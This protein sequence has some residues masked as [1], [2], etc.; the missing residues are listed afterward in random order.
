MKNRNLLRDNLVDH[1]WVDCEGKETAR[2]KPDFYEK[3][4]APTDPRTGNVLQ[5]SHTECTGLGDLVATLDSVQNNLLQKNKNEPFIGGLV[6][7]VKGIL[8]QLRS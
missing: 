2:V 5:Y 8:L 3:N 7:R 6:E 4:G 1:V